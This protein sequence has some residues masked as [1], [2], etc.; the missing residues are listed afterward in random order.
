MKLK[1]AAPVLGVAAAIVIALAAFQL[2]SNVGGPITPTPTPRHF[3]R[4]DL[5][6]IVLTDANAPAGLD[7]DGTEFGEAALM[8]PMKAGGPAIDQTGFIDARMTN[9]NSIDTGG[10]VTWSALFETAPM[11]RLRSTSSSA[12][13]DR[14][15][16]E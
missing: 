6:D 16:G 7:V 9:L 5:P 12:S 2:G 8:V 10:Y 1:P 13:T 4:A 11:P 15:A 3:T 14:A